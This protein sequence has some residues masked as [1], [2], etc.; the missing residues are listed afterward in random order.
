MATSSKAFAYRAADVLKDMSVCSLAG[1]FLH[2]IEI[3]VDQEAVIVRRDLLL[4]AI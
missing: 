3:A 2:L 4:Q 1:V